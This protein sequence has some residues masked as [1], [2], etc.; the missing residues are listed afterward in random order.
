MVNR[1]LLHIMEL[2]HHSSRTPI[3][4]IFSK[5]ITIMYVY[6][7][8]YNRQRLEREVYYV[9]CYCNIFM[10]GSSHCKWFEKNKSF[11]SAGRL[12]CTVWEDEREAKASSIAFVVSV[13]QRKCDRYFHSMVPGS[14]WVY[15]N[16]F[17][18]FVSESQSF[19]SH[20]IPLVE[21]SEKVPTSVQSS[22]PRVL[23][24]SSSISLPSLRCSQCQAW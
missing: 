3:Q 15:S 14:L 23:S 19:K 8:V 24:K 22:D 7:I 9:L 13:H 6:C 2:Q 5:T 4:V 16:A 18:L 10:A 20:V 11:F 17:V 21:S 12:R 1:A